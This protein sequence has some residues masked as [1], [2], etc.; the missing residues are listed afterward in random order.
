MTDATRALDG[1]PRPVTPIAEE[2]RLRLADAWGEMGAAWGV[3]PAIARV[4][5]YLMSGVSQRTDAFIDWG[6]EEFGTSRVL[7]TSD[8]SRFREE[9]E[10]DG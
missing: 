10:T 9:G 6:W 7:D 8:T 1:S 4:H 2:I 3:A 5:A